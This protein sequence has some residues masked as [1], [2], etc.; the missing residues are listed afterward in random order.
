LGIVVEEE[1]EEERRAT[2]TK[3]C[4]LE[5]LATTKTNCHDPLGSFLR[6]STDIQLS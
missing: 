6:G 5:N 1:E 4:Y 3:A 2:S